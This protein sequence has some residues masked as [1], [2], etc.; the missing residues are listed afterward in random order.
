[1]VIKAIIIT[2]T[3]LLRFFLRWVP[4]HE[5]LIVLSPCLRAQSLSY[6]MAV[7]R[8]GLQPLDEGV[9]SGFWGSIYDYPKMNR[10]V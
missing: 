8:T 1:M 10:T 2:A 7:R 9:E 6:R 4:N 5:I 3:S